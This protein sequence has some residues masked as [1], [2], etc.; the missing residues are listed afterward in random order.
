[1]H[2]AIGSEDI[3]GGSQVHRATG[4]ENQV[5]GF[6][7]RGKFDAELAASRSVLKLAGV[8]DELVASKPVMLPVTVAI[9]HW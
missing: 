7:V 4:G 2:F 8:H 5:H 3:G 1:M 6:L 9:G